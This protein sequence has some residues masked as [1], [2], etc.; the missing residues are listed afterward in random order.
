MIE[1]VD[2]L[3]MKVAIS[4]RIL[5]V[6]GLVRDSTGHVSARIP[7]TDEM[8]IRCRG[9]DEM[10]LEFTGLHNI[11]RV[12][13]DGDGPGMGESHAKPHETAIHGELYRARP[14]VMAVVHAHPPYA[15]RCG[16]TDIPFLPVFNA[17]DPSALQIVTKGVPV[18]PRAIT[19]TNR[20][21][22]EEMVACMGD[23][24]VLLMRGHGT[25]VTASTVESATTQAIRFDNLAQIM[26][27]LATSGQKVRQLPPEDMPQPRA[28]GGGG[29]RTGWGALE[30]A[31]TWGWKH[32]VRLLS[33]HHLLED[34]TQEAAMM[35]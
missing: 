30:G 7:G 5:G 14:D 4:C 6:L 8:W 3:R 13:F 27:D 19:V 21:L 24:D 31:E 16:V 23:R 34:L 1:A 9:G 12:N 18:F 15:L 32:Y 17:Y 25:V 11:R 10:G 35:R 26:W 33:H 20:Q 29:E 2:E 22:G 28:G